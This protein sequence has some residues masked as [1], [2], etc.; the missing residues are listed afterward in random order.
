MGEMLLEEEERLLPPPLAEPLPLP[1]LR[2]VLLA[3]ARVATVCAVTVTAAEAA[4][5][6]AGAG[7]GV[8][9]GWSAAA[10]VAVTGVAGVEAALD[11]ADLLAAEVRV[12]RDRGVAMAVVGCA[13]K[14]SL[15]V[16]RGPGQGRE[17]RSVP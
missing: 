9:V 7:A 1:A 11:A 15:N 4:A 13:L 2:P 10:G 16:G 12:A 6:A 3:T 5:A 14:G 17:E 8:A